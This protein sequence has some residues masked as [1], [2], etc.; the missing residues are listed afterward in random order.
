MPRSRTSG[1]I[2]Q[3]GKPREPYSIEKRQLSANFLLFN[4]IP[5]LLGWSLGPDAHQSR[6]SD[7]ASGPSWFRAPHQ[8]FG[9][10]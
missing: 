1:R 10:S 4:V 2:G 5:D 7:A 8:R 9:V 6:T 3:F